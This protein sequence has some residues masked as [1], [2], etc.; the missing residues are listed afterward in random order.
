MVSIEGENNGVVVDRLTERRRE[1]KENCVCGRAVFVGRGKNDSPAY[2]PITGKHQL[3][4][5]EFF[6]MNNVGHKQV[7]FLP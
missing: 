3:L 6:D 2:G 5:V 4:A 7:G 1:G